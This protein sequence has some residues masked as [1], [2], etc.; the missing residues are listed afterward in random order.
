MVSSAKS[1]ELILRQ[2]LTNFELWCTE[3]RVF[4]RE[5]NLKKNAL[6]K[7]HFQKQQRTITSHHSSGNNNQHHDDDNE[8]YDFIIILDDAPIS[9]SRSRK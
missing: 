9:F 5:A 8:W 3:G 4:T 2:I 6:N 7:S 1:D